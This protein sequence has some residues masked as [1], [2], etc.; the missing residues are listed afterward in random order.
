VAG[1]SAGSLSTQPDPTNG[2]HL[3]LVLTQPGGTS[4]LTLTDAG[5]GGSLGGTLAARDGALEGAQAS[6]DQLA[7]DLST[8]LN[9]VNEAGFGL[10]GSTGLPLFTTGATVSGAAGAMALA[11]ANP[12][13]LALSATSGASGDSTNAQA[14]IAT[15]STPLSTGADVT[16]TLASIT[17]QYGTAASD[18]QAMSTQDSAMSQNLLTQRASFSGVSTDSELITLQS[19]QHAYEAISQVITTTNNMMDVLLN[20]TTVTT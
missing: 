15:Q 11:I 9:T 19:A 18:A 7:S 2:G 14:L 8:S 1:T 4:T 5:V 20:M 13:Q 3:G 6:V 10:D 12:N 17:S 16:D